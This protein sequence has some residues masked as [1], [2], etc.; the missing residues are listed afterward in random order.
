MGVEREVTRSS[1]EIDLGTD[2][3]TSRILLVDDEPEVLDFYRDVLD[4]VNYTLETANNGS[5]A[6]ELLRARGFL[7]DAIVV[8]TSDHGEH[9]GEHGMLDHRIS[10]YD[11]LLRVPLVVHRP[12]RYEGGAVVQAEVSLM[13]VYS[14]ILAEAGVAV[15][16]GTGLD[17]RPLP[18]MAACC[19]RQTRPRSTRGCGGARR[20][21]AIQFR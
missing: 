12:G 10:L 19:S 9:L 20:T 1:G 15:P 4:H 14:T 3:H 6:L 21:A 16:A 13:D 18:P 8:V 17:A 2:V 5:E 11:T 7:K